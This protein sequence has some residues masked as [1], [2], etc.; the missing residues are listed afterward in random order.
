MFLRG[1]TI[2]KDVVQLSEQKSISFKIS[3]ILWKV[4]AAFLRPKNMVGN[5]IMPKGVVRPS[6]I[7]RRGG[8]GS[9]DVLLRVRFWKRW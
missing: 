2:N 3:M 4:W 8:R 5:L 1:S 9:G 7:C 6:F